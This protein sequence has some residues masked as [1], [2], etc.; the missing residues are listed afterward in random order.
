MFY[1]L[2]LCPLIYSSIVRIL[3]V[4]HGS[5]SNQVMSPSSFGESAAELG[6]VPGLV[7]VSGARPQ[8]AP[9]AVGSGHGPS[10]QPLKPS[11]CLSLPGLCCWPVSPFLCVL[12]VEV[13][14]DRGGWVTGKMGQLW[15][16]TV[17]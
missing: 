5:I 4:S 14:A 15:D 2:F 6:L 1:L 12:G 16:L 11:G 17:N 3:N 10:L 7:A 8:G 9:R 13:A